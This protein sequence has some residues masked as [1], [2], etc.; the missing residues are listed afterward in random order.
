[1][2][3]RDPFSPMSLGLG[4]HEGP[5]PLLGQC[6]STR[7]ETHL[8]YGR[9]CEHL[10]RSPDYWAQVLL[11]HCFSVAWEVWSCALALGPQELGKPF[12]QG[13][14]LEDKAWP[15]S[16]ENVRKRQKLKSPHGTN[17]ENPRVRGLWET[18]DRL[19]YERYV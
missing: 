13:D 12:S 2:L 17:S 8:K 19:W 14:L 18:L 6:V 3:S 10:T 15:I 4:W 16:P 7:Q 11:L 9:R 1:M 5:G